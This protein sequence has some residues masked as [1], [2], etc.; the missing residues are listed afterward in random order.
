MEAAQRVSVEI[1]GSTFP[2]SMSETSD[3]ETPAF[4]AS[5]LML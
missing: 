1:D 5:P 3:A 4:A 2:F